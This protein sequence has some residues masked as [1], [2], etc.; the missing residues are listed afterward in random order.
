MA[1]SISELE[2]ERAKILEQIE[3]RAKSMSTDTTN[4]S[5]QDWLKAAEDVVPQSALEA[6]QQLQN[7]RQR[8][9][10]TE[11]HNRVNNDDIPLVGQTL[12]TPSANNDPYS[13]ATLDSSPG[14]TLAFSDD[15]FADD[16]AQINLSS[17][18]T[19]S[20][21]SDPVNNKS[22]R[23]PDTHSGFSAQ[24]YAPSSNTKGNKA[25]MMA[26]IAIMLSLFITILVVV[27]MGYNSV[28]KEINEMQAQSEANKNVIAELQQ[29]IA[30]MPLNAEA[31]LAS[32]N[33]NQQKISSLQSQIV[34][35]EAQLATVRN[36]LKNLQQASAEQSVDSSELLQQK[37]EKVVSALKDSAPTP[38]DLQPVKPEV[39][40]FKAAVNIAIEPDVERVKAEQSNADIEIPV[41]PSEPE[42]TEPKAAGEKNVAEPE[43]PIIATDVKVAEPKKN[44]S[45]DVKWLME[46]P[47]DNY[48]LQLASMLE[49]ASIE[50]M[51]K[52]KGIKE[53]RLI[54]QL[55]DGKTMYVLIVGS[56]AERKQA[57]KLASELKNSLGIA[58]WIRTAQAVLKRVD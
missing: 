50:K 8:L 35:L 31:T 51:I 20:L 15:D 54:P 22:M 32:A 57:D 40:P 56:F 49:A 28:H 3:S 12:R 18:T 9:V 11:Q 10:E 17:N 33:E 7:A 53:G 36:D 34:A 30:D 14:N 45:R 21:E 44:Y 38:E 27:V 6:E 58:P 19:A 46:Q 37:I 2:A 43:M 55:R 52:D 42:I 24:E 41:A 23:Q 39:R 4:T 13:R 48:T 26:G 5:L 47:S 16:I 29:K 25:P 1:N